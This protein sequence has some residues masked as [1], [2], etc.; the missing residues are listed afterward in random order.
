MPC[1]SFLHLPSPVIRAFANPQPPLH[2]TVDLSAG[3]FLP[4][5]GLL[6]CAVQPHPNCWPQSCG[7]FLAVPT[8]PAEVSGILWNTATKH[9]D[10]LV[11]LNVKLFKAINSRGSLLSNV[12][13]L[14]LGHQLWQVLSLQDTTSAVGL[15]DCAGIFVPFNKIE[16]RNKNQPPAV[17]GTPLKTATK[18]QFLIKWPLASLHGPRLPWV[19]PDSPNGQALS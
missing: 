9:F 18:N 16:A 19:P 5:A 17:L 6:D 14:M 2:V 11:I 3:C 15:Q 7:H 8:S 12:S 4:Q 10:S 13:H 1:P